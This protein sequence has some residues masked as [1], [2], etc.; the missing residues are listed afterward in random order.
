MR[1]PR[2]V[3]LIWLVLLSKVS[4]GAFVASEKG[5]SLSSFFVFHIFS[6]VI[7]YYLHTF[8]QL[9]THTQFLFHCCLFSF[10]L[11]LRSLSPLCARRVCVCVCCGQIFRRRC[12]ANQNR[13]PSVYICF[14]FYA[15]LA[16]LSFGFY[17]RCGGATAH[18]T[19]SMRKSAP[20]KRFRWGT[21]DRRNIDR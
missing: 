6:F 5:L 10:I 21:D 13:K 11:P 7:C 8:R 17:L 18:R 2:I 19:K 14:Y 1:P 15:S 4:S 3:R 12:A 20:S 9:F 16:R